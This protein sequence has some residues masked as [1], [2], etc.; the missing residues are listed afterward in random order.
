MVVLFIRSCLDIVCCHE[1]FMHETGCEMILNL[2]IFV[3]GSKTG[4]EF[5]GI[6]IIGGYCL[7]FCA[8]DVIL[9]R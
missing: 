9:D 3:F 8:E 7:Y 6:Y 4:F 5:H 1:I 2:L